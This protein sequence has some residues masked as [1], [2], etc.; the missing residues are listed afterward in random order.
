MD[1]M[2]VF[3]F[4]MKKYR[5]K[6]KLSQMKLAEKLNTST[7]YIGEIEIK[8]KVPSME[9][10]EKIAGALGVEPYRLFVDNKCRYESIADNYL[11]R[12]SSIERQDLS[13]RLITQ[14]SSRV[15]NIL[16]PE[17]EENKG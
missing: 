4:N 15:K 16:Q 7:S 3:A 9:M 17:Y 2:E 6:S 10:V 8:Q 13:E 14:M 11:E 1:I 5:K 12:L